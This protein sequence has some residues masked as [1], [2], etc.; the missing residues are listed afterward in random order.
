MEYLSEDYAREGICETGRK[1]Y[2]RGFVAG[3]DGNI[4]VR[5]DENEIIATPTRVSKGFMTPEILLKMDLNGNVLKDGGIPPTSEIK[6]HLRIFREC[7]DVQAVIHTHSPIATAYACAQI[8][9]D[10]ALLLEN[11]VIL[12]VVPCTEFALAGSDEVPNVVARYCKDHN[13]LLLGNHGVLVW[14]NSLTDACF[15]SETLEHYAKIHLITRY[16]LKSDRTLSAR[17]RDRL[18]VLRKKAGIEKG[19]VPRVEGE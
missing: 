1:I 7:P 14:G 10:D 19:G 8:P 2:Q 5:I 4:S 11:V 13:A 18:L 12:G 17:D 6:M 9:L 3:N 15:R 16:I